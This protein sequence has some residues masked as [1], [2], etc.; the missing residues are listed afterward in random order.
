VSIVLAVLS[1]VFGGPRNPN[2]RM[3]IAFVAL[4]IASDGLSSGFGGLSIAF[5]QL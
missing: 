5:G 3:S 2:F 1:M 4:S